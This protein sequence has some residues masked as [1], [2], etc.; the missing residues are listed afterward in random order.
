MK[1]ADSS[2][3]NGDL[4][5]FDHKKTWGLTASSHWIDLRK[6]PSSRGCSRQKRHVNVINCNHRINCS[7]FL[8]KPR[9]ETLVRS[10]ENHG[11]HKQ[12]C[13]IWNGNR[14]IK[15]WGCY[16]NRTGQSFL[17]LDAFIAAPKTP[18]ELSNLTPKEWLVRMTSFKAVFSLSVHSSLVDSQDPRA[19]PVPGTG[20]KL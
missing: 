7:L 1:A 8:R 16:R 19:L 9:I 15:T 14:I 10:W 11:Y 12:N 20:P 6:A 17:R 3:K 13:G 5:W 2:S 4:T 18:S